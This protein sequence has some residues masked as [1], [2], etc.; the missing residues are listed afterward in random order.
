VDDSSKKLHTKISAPPEG[1][2]PNTI[3]IGGWESRC[4]NCGGIAFPDEGSHKTEIHNNKEIFIEDKTG[5]FPDHI[6]PAEEGRPGCGMVWKYMY[7]E[8]VGQKEAC[9]Q[10][11]PKYK[12]VGLE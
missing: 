6:K 2:E 12:W 8:Y 7:C 10:L 1:L 9:E 4:L 3:I 11:W 5:Q